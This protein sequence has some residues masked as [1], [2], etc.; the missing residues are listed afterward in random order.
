MKRYT[1]QSDFWKTAKILGYLANFLKN[2]Q[3]MIFE[4]NIFKPVTNLPE[5]IDWGEEDQGSIS[6]QASRTGGERRS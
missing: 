5:D 3:G 2:H 1:E 6:P 4:G